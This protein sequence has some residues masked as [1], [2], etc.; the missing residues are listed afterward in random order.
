MYL[1][2]YILYFEQSETILIDVLD[3]N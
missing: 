3:T 2:F 1:L